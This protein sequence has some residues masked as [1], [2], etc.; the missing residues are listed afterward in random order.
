MAI[1]S[2]RADSPHVGLVGLIG[3]KVRR[4]TEFIPGWTPG[5][6]PLVGEQVLHPARWRAS[7]R[8]GPV[9]SSA[10]P[11]QGSLRRQTYQP[12]QPEK[13]ELPWV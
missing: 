5:G 2:R 13:G 6:V 3:A 4:D 8:V 1:P 7:T 11:D 12:V 10:D 9:E